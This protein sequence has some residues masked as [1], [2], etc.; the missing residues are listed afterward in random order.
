MFGGT[1]IDRAVGVVD[2]REGVDHDW[3]FHRWRSI[4]KVPDV[5]DNAAVR[6][7]MERTGSIEGDL[8][9]W[10]MVGHIGTGVSHWTRLY[11]RLFQSQ[12]RP[13]G[14]KGMVRPIP[15]IPRTVWILISHDMLGISSR[16][17]TI[18]V[19]P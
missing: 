13:G 9:D 6:V 12:D 18:P 10:G 5:L 7:A 2:C 11:N 3:T 19:K 14:L 8:D 15:P 16:R 4:A 17:V 1:P